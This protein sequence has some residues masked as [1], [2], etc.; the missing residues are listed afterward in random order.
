MTDLDRLTPAER[1]KQ[2]G[3]P[4][5]ELGLAIAEG[6]NETNRH[7]YDG[8]IAL[9]ALKPGFKVLEIGFGNGR[10]VPELIR[11]AEGV[12]YT[13]IDISQTMVD[14]ARRFNAPFVAAGR[15]RFHLA[16]A[17]HMPFEDA[18]FDRVF[19]IGVKHF[20]LDPAEPLAE[21]R[22]VLRPGG[23]SIMSS[24]HPRWAPTLPVAR[25]E[26][27]FH[28]RD[29]ETW[30]ALHREAGFSHVVAETI[31]SVQ[32]RADGSSVMRYLVRVTAQ[33]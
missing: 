21:V 24:I 28:L 23:V 20:W 12:T 31:E 29:E 3:N 27:G 8:L 19:A 7:E 11:Q 5:G 4:E 15:T 16:P 2:L 25:A 18:Q 6:L 22:R 14:V 17:E 33:R 13:G 1:A 32:T 26:F 30:V 9:L 10:L